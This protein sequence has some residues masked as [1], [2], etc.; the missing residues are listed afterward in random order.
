MHRDRYDAS[1]QSQTPKLARLLV[2][3]EIGCHALGHARSIILFQRESSCIT[4]LPIGSVFAERLQAPP[5]ARPVLPQGWVPFVNVL[6]QFENWP[7]AQLARHLCS[8]IKVN[9]RYN[10]MPSRLH[11]PSHVPQATFRFR[12][13]HVAEEVTRHHHV[14]MS[15]DPHQTRITCIAQLP[16]DSF[17][18][19]RFDPRYLAVT[20]KHFPKFRISHPLE[21]R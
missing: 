20:L 5:L 14:L 12:G 16:A 9:T 19:P 6:D 17:P 3:L 1:T 21:Y 10:E 2:V 15:N 4:H 13:L 18:N 7:P 8:N 11:Q